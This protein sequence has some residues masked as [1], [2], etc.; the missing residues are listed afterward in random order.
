MAHTQTGAYASLKLPEPVSTGSL[1]V[2]QVAIDS[3]SEV[4]TIQDSLG[5]KYKELRDRGL[6]AWLKRVQRKLRLGPKE[7]RTAV[8]VFVATV[9]HIGAY[10]LWVQ[11]PYTRAMSAAVY[12][13]ES[14]TD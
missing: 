9:N 1:L 11:A 14:A 3:M 10:E 12:E 5:N 4:E 8:Q 6:I 2:V 13:V 7:P